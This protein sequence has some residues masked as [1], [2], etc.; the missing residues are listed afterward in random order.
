MEPRFESVDRDHLAWMLTALDGRIESELEENDYRLH[1]DYVARA[2]LRFAA[3]F[4]SGDVHHD[5]L[6]AARCLS[7][8]EGLHFMKVP[9]ER[10]R[11]RRIDP[12]ELAAGSG[13]AQLARNVAERYGLPIATLL[14]DLADED[15]KREIRTVTR[16]FDGPA[17]DALDVAGLGAIAYCA[18]LAAIL[19]GFD[20][21][22]MLAVQLFRDACAASP[23][24]E[25]SEGPVGRYKALISLLELVASG[26]LP[27]AAAT[28]GELVVAHHESLR[29]DLPEADWVKPRV[30]PRYF[31]L[32][33]VAF[34]AILAERGEALDVEA[35]PDAAA[36]YRDLLRVEAT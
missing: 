29:V 34:A 2:Q 28:V 21:E 6:W 23:H 13:D 19:R 4:D 5:L 3:G 31:D 33:S 26:D 36:P 24:G 14:A 18:G 7:F 35:L 9:P 25:G 17:E 1:R 15:V 8:N 16:L 12:L 10:F 11:S 32:M 30:A 22:A 20:D 27:G